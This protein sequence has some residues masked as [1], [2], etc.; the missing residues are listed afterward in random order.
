[1]KVGI[2]EQD[3]FEVAFTVIRLFDYNDNRITIF[4][5]KKTFPR[6]R[7]LFKEDISRYNWVI[8]N[9]EGGKLT[10]FRHLFG[11]LKKERFELIYL[12]TISD[13]HLLYALMLWLLPRTRVVLTVHDINCLFQP[14]ASLGFKSI[15]RKLGKRCLTRQVSAYNVISDTMLPYLQEKNS[16]QKSIYSIPGSVYQDRF[17]R[18]EIA[19]YIHLVIPGSIEKKR[20]NYDEAINLI[21]EAE[22]RKLPL[23]VTFLG[24]AVD[25]YGKNILEHLAKIPVSFVQVKYYEISSVPQEEFDK[26][27]DNCHFVYIPSMVETISCENIPEVYGI[28]KSSGSIFDGIKHGKPFIIP[29]RLVVP[30]NISSHCIRYSSFSHLATT[31]YEYYQNPSL[32]IQVRDRAIDNSAN[33]TTEKIR[34][35]YKHLFK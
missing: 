2:Y 30:E 3:H 31:L 28:T 7:E 23:R 4:T 27:L 20:R 6:F 12:N 11:L 34:A 15:I 13:N 1:M 35:A 10:R 21:M 16:L 17:N 25:E 8:E 26:Q 5:N 22:Q 29:E 19:G 18:K 33:Y 24:A 14:D 32:Y 9:E